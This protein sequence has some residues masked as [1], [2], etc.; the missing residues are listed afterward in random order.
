MAE[1][2]RPVDETG[3]VARLLSRELLR[4][5]WRELSKA[6]SC[7]ISFLNADIDVP[8]LI[9]L[10]FV[11]VFSGRGGGLCAVLVVVVVTVVVEFVE[12]KDRTLAT[13]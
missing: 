6:F 2:V 13:D 3:E 7:C 12:R 4:L 11:F 5:D 10:P 9:P 1:A 8:V